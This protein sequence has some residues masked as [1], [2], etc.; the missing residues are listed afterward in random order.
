MTSATR[1]I[2]GT[3]LRTFDQLDG[4]AVRGVVVDAGEAGAGPDA[5]LRIG[6]SGAVLAQVAD[7]FVE[8]VNL[9]ADREE[10]FAALFHLLVEAAGLLDRLHELK[11]GLSNRKA[12]CL[13]A[14]AERVV[15]LGVFLEANVALPEAEGVVKVIR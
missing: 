1:A 13:E 9:D 10:A 2:R 4:D 6:D 7:G 5:G 8:I 14:G 3:A 15:E 12:R 11:E